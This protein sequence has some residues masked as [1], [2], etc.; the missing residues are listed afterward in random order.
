M[1]D[2]RPEMLDLA[3]GLRCALTTDEGHFEVKFEVEIISL[4]SL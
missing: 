3:E 4:C 2:F 1:L